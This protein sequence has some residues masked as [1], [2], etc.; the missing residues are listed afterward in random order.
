MIDLLAAWRGLDG[1]T[2]EGEAVVRLDEPDL[3]AP[4]AEAAAEHWRASLVRGEQTD[5]APMPANAQGRPR[6][7]VTGELAREITAV[8]Q[9]D[10]SYSIEVVGERTEAAARV[11]ADLDVWSQE[12][13]D[14]PAMTAAL[15]AV[16][17]R[18]VGGD[19]G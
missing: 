4:L 9:G 6:G 13:Q 19:N 5:G 17:E 7:Y 8:P 2:V 10:G 11:Y 16:A 3:L 18:I 14:S 15:Q 1:V 12:A